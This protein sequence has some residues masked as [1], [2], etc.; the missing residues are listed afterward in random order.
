[1][2]V[3]P[4]P[5]FEVGEVCHSLLAC[6]IGLNIGDLITTRA[7]LVHGGAESNPVMRGI[8]DSTMHASFVKSLCL[9]VVVALVVR[10]RLPGRVAWLLAAVNAWYLFVVG[11]NLTVLAHT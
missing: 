4:A 2:H 9:I 6:L 3:L 5:R 11:W 1:M 7:V 8:V 10:T